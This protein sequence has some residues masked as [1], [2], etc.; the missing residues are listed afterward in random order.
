MFSIFEYNIDIFRLTFT[1]YMRGSRNIVFE[2]KWKETPE[3][4]QHKGAMNIAVQ[5][6][7]LPGTQHMKETFV[8]DIDFF[9]DN[10]CGFTLRGLFRDMPMTDERQFKYFTRNF[11]VVS[12]GD[13]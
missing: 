10:L 2:E 1:T 11:L 6:S 3:R 9:Q 7:K 5:L 13:G 4:V 8:L 12:T